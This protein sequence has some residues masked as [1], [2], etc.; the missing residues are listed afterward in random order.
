MQPLETLAWDPLKAACSPSDLDL[1]VQLTK[2]VGLNARSCDPAAA[3]RQ[4]LL[5]GAA[6][7]SCRDI[8]LQFAH[9]TLFRAG[10]DLKRAMTM[11]CPGE[12]NQS[13]FIG[14]VVAQGHE[15]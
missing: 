8:T 4:P 1:F 2:A 11:L 13:V 3:N 7:A 15:T 5:V 9:D 12:S 10:Y 14:R 6:A